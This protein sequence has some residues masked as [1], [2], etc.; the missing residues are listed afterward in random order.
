MPYLGGLIRSGEGASGRQI[1]GVRA[2]SAR[3]SVPAE[4]LRGRWRGWW[5]IIRLLP[6]AGRVAAVAMAFN[7]LIGVLPFGFV[8]GTSVAVERVTRA[9]QGGWGGILVAVGLAVGSLLL[10]AAL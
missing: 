2:P 6:V 10:Q 8:I 7:L 1:R 5:S 4:W 9:G 3:W